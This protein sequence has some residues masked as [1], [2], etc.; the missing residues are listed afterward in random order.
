MSNQGSRP[1][2]IRVSRVLIHGV[3]HF[4]ITQFFVFKLPSYQHTAD[5]YIVEFQNL[6]L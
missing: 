2:N 3:K 1:Y 5:H 6:K 4:H